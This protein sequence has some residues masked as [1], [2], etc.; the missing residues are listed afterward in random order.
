MFTLFM[1]IVLSCADQD[2]LSSKFVEN[3]KYTADIHIYH[4]LHI[5]NAGRK[6]ITKP[7][8]STHFET[9]HFEDISCKNYINSTYHEGK[10]FDDIIPLLQKAYAYEEE[11]DENFIHIAAYVTYKQRYCN[12]Y[13]ENK[14]WYVDYSDGFF[15]I[16]HGTIDANTVN[17]PTCIPTDPTKSDIFLRCFKGVWR[18]NIFERT[19]LGGILARQEEE[20]DNAEPLALVVIVIIGLLLF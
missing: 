4:Q 2:Y 5:C 9:R 18:P 20:C 13:T 19:N 15:Y 11:S 14:L 7:Y 6:T 17:Y 10:Y 12:I 8:N 16:Q 1:F 3:L